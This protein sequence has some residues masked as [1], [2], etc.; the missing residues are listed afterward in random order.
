MDSGFLARQPKLV[1]YFDPRNHS[2]NYVPTFLNTLYIHPT[3]R[4]SLGKP[5]RPDGEHEDCDEEHR[6]VTESF[7]VEVSHLTSFQLFA[8]LKC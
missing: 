7:I 5:G 8:T 1:H 6:E 3:Y 4:G 2:V